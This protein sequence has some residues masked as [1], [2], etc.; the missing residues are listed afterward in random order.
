MVIGLSACAGGAPPKPTWK[1]EDRV[2]VHVQL[3]WGYLQRDQLNI[4]RTELEQAL[5]LDSNHSRA[6]HIMAILQIRLKNP[7]VADRHFRRAVQSDPE[8][9]D[10]KNDY[11]VF[12]CDRGRVADGMRQFETALESPLNKR[13]EM[14]YVRA[15]TCLVGAADLETAERYLRAALKIDPELATALYLVARIQHESGNDLSARA[16]LQRFFDTGAV[17]SQSLLLA[18]QVERRLGAKDLETEYARRLKASYPNSKEAQE[19]G[20][21]GESGAQ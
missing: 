9:I 10:A 19:L 11:G 16:H 4:A 20:A 3:G 7:N 8:N 14:T 18:V 2:D 21:V 6:N 15:G 1:S 12:L 13:L 5:A 17:S